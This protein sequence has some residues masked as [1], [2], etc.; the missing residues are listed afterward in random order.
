MNDQKEALA[1]RAMPLIAHMRRGIALAEQIRAVYQRELDVILMD[2]RACATIESKNCEAQRVLQRRWVQLND[3]VLQADGKLRALGGSHLTCA[4]ITNMISV[5][6]SV[7]AM[8]G[9]RV[10]EAKLDAYKCTS[11]D[12]DCVVLRVDTLEER[13]ERGFAS[14][15]DLDTE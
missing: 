2:A 10:V 6:E 5:Y 4:D 1:T 12:E 11:Q 13:N 8:G 7:C 15:I 9:I 14:A 3:E